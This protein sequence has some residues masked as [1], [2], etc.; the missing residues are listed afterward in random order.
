METMYT[1]SE[2]PPEAPSEEIPLLIE[3]F[4]CANSFEEHVKVIEQYLAAL[5]DGEPLL[6]SFLVA[7]VSAAAGG[8]APADRKS[9]ADI[10]NGA[11]A[12][13]S[14]PA[15]PTTTSSSPASLSVNG[16]AANLSTA[17]K[18][19]GRTISLYAAD[20]ISLDK[21]L[22]IAVEVHVR[23]ATHPI[24]QQYCTPL[25]FLIKKAV[26]S[27]SYRESETSYL[28]SLL[29]TAVR[30]M[31]LQ[32][33][34]NR[35]KG[36]VLRLCPA[37]RRAAAPGCAPPSHQQQ[38]LA[39]S[40]LPSPFFYPDGCAP[41]FAPAGD[42]YK[43]TFVGVAPPL[44]TCAALPPLSV[45]PSSPSPTISAAEWLLLHQRSFTTRFL[46]DAFGRVPEHCQSLSDY[47]DL[48]QLHVGQHS[49]IRSDDFDGICVSLWKK[50]V[51]PV[52]WKFQPYG[53]STDSKPNSGGNHADDAQAADG[54]GVP[55]SAASSSLTWESV[56][57]RENE[58]ARL[59]CGAFTHDFGTAAPPLKH[60]RFHFQWNQLQDIEAH[61]AVG[62]A[63]HLDPFQ[64][65]LT[66]T[67][68]GTAPP[69]VLAFSSASAAQAVQRKCSITA[70]A[71]VRDDK[72]IQ[73]GVSEHLAEVL[74]GGYLESLTNATAARRTISARDGN[75]GSGGRG[76]VTDQV[77]RPG[78]DE[79]AGDKDESGA[80]ER[81]GGRCSEAQLR[82]LA[83]CIVEWAD[84]KV[85][86]QESLIQRFAAPLTSGDDDD[87]RGGDD[88]NVY[89]DGDPGLPQSPGAALAALSG[90]RSEAVVAR[91]LRSLW[92]EWE[93]HQQCCS[94]ETS[95]PHRQ[96][97][98]GGAEHEKDLRRSYFPDSFFARFAFVCATQVPHP[99]DV[100]ALWRL[101]LDALHRLLLDAP[102][103]QK[104]KSWQRLLDCLAMPPEDPPV[105]LGRP[106]LTQKLQLLRYAQEALLRSLE[107]NGSPTTAT[108][109]AST[110]E[111]ENVAA[112]SLTASP[113]RYLITNGEVLCVPPP[114]PQPPT[115]AD[116][117]VKR[118]VELNSLDAT[119]VESASVEWLQTDALYNDMCFFLYVN[120]A[121]E[122]RIVRFPDFVQW[123]SPRD[124]V[125]S[126]GA[127]ST[128]S[129]SVERPSRSLSDN[130]YLSERMQRQQKE[131]GASGGKGSAH[132]WWSLWRRATPRSRDDIVH[133]LFQPLEQ[134]TKILAWLAAMPTEELLLEVSNASIANALHHMLCHRCVLGDDGA[135][136]PSGRGR[137][138]HKADRSSRMPLST[139]EAA[140]YT[141]PAT[142]RIRDLHR[143][144]REKCAALT[145]D[146]E[147]ASALFLTSRGAF[148]EGAAAQQSAAESEAMITEMLHGFFANALHQLGE[149]EVSVCTAVALQYLLG[150]STNPEVAATVHALSSPAAMSQQHQATSLQMRIV[151][152]S[153]ATWSTAFAK[154]F[155]RAETREVQESMLR[156]TCMA[157]RPL[158]TCACFQQLVVHQDA[159]RSLRLA[160]ALTKEVL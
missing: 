80:D 17:S 74:L 145:K 60:V 76:V 54:D 136:Q 26:V 29:S 93:A 107:D 37:S 147:A 160:L 153:M 71:V 13:S 2:S 123:H 143:Y 113:V 139:P 144:V 50:Y 128:T 15:S 21:D 44:P 55:L 79:G 45:P 35:V 114:L 10:E 133:G 157:E 49:R 67:A 150:F 77:Q 18:V 73:H 124:F 88:A 78:D 138:S 36:G 151:T 51:L 90:K 148:G 24:M 68:P 125:A 89:G 56:L 130:D 69:A 11:A 52:P 61:E 81:S 120:K 104:K 23:D 4:S 66:T 106:L 129:P 97:R 159:S 40:L 31:L 6:Q 27:A 134:A 135:N 96:Q 155:A 16:E 12:S 9:G 91:H 43:Q 59:L 108:P 86:L 20:P 57:R 5:F 112:T 64:Y 127:E 83:A 53:L 122:G 34:K 84:A 137:P 42:S 72:D 105:D 47:I 7:P 8:D 141:I 92:G 99:T 58:Y 117:V 82:D 121:H 119:A 98:K 22:S 46:A 149:I 109:A 132:V 14:S 102:H 142:P 48:F 3:D 116:E 154:Q 146:V 25:F 75:E 101:C 110:K 87:A 30:Q 41:C 19:F 39:T 85:T 65:A 152:V 38:A 158:D 111:E 156:L 1:R 140:H 126:A 28:L 62:R 94:G 115:T 32:Q 118:A 70:Q 63:S 131:C 33:Q 100:Q 103:E 95:A